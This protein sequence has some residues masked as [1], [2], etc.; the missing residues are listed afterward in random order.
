MLN[1]SVYVY[2][3]MYVCMYVYMYNDH[4]I[5]SNGS[6]YSLEGILPGIHLDHPDSSDHLIHDTNTSVCLLSRFE[7]MCKCTMNHT[8]EPPPD[9]FYK[10]NIHVETNG[11]VWVSRLGGD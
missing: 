5:L 3:C 9:S 6:D 7:S 4:N 11:R 2:V 10:V 1:D 8:S